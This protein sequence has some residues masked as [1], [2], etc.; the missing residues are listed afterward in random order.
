MPDKLILNHQ[1]GFRAG[2]SYCVIWISIFALPGCLGSIYGWQVRTTST[3]F[4]PSYDPV[5]L[6]QE[7]VAIL[8]ALTMAGLRG[9]ELGLD[10]LL[11]EVLHKVA[12]QMRVIDSRQSLSQINQLGLAAEYTQMRADAEQSHVLNRDSLKKIGT[13]LG[14]RYVFQPRLASFTQ[15][16]TDRWTFPGFGVLLMQTRSA[17]LRVSLQL[18]DT[19][20]G[21]LLWVSMAEGTLQSEAASRDLV[22]FEDAARVALGSIVADLLNQK[23]ASTYTPLNKILDE[24]IQIPTP[25]AKSDGAKTTEPSAQ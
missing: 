7:P 8:G 22:Y 1:K 18:W 9:N 6:G 3:A 5:T 19:K 25:E 20:T 17:D 2:F 15:I 21:A 11:G 12:P 10:Y 23:T 13:A 24:L 4:S 14:A 16:M